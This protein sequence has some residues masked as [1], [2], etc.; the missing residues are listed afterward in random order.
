[1]ECLISLA[2]FRLT[3]KKTP[4]L[5]ITGPLYEDNPL[6][7]NGLPSQK[8][9]NEESVSM[10]WDYYGASKLPVTTYDVLCTAQATSHYLN[11]WWTSSL[12]HIC[13]TKPQWINHTI[14]IICWRSC[15]WKNDIHFVISWIYMSPF[16]WHGFTLIS[17]WKSNYINYVGWNYF[18]CLQVQQCN[19]WSLG[20]DK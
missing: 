19:P 1:M 10:S 17:T 15:P 4:K 18:I 9:S 14:N 3:S 11:Q 20:M 8:A 12:V 5:H 6:V 2:L 16:Y 7:T 13:I